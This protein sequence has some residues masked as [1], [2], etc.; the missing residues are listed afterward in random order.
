MNIFRGLVTYLLLLIYAG[1]INA[2][3]DLLPTSTTGQVV[4][5]TYYVLS[6]SEVH[7]QPEWVY[8]KLTASF[9]KGPVSRT[10]DFRP[11]PEVSTG[12]AQLYDYKGSGYD[13][14]HL[15]P[16][17]DMKLS[18]HSMSE[19]FYMSNMSPQEPAFN[20]G[21][22][23]NLE[24]TVRNW[25]VEEGEIYVVTGG[26]L[27]GIKGTIGSNRVAVPKYYYKVIYD[28]SGDKKMIALVLPNEKS[29]KPLQS[30]VVSVDSVE[31]LTGIDFF[32]E[33]NDVLENHLESS[34]D[35]SLWSFSKYSASSSHSSSKAGAV[36]C[37]GISA[38]TGQR[39]KI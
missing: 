12:S 1:T 24:A 7:E 28:P 37:K 11:D 38:S 16:A 29:I 33:L 20:R 31:E 6:Y 27:S 21:I 22:W 4:K 39:C 2:T 30:Y 35:P 13:R 32:H 19:T 25:A 26:V 14:G 34:S 15:C 18:R 3:G 5:H 9:V 23:K 17:G 10:D 36:Q 8:Y